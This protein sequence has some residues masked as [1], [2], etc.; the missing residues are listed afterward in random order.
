MK[1]FLN[2]KNKIHPVVRASN[3]F[4]MLEDKNDRNFFSSQNLS[5]ASVPMNRVSHSRFHCR[6]LEKN[7]VL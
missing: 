7:G 3:P 1:Y 2:K 4:K 6:D 5:Q